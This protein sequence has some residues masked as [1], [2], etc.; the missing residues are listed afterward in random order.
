MESQNPI[1]RMREAAG[2]DRATLAR[3][4]KIGYSS[5]DN[6]ENGRLR[7]LGPISAINLSR[8]LGTDPDTLQQAYS[9]WRDMP[10]EQLEFH[11]ESNQTH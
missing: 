10:A 6:I 8:A 11:H 5:L 7:H 2:L 4:A 3:A 1:K 9:Q